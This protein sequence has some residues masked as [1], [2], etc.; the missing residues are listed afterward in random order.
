MYGEGVS[1][2]GEILDLGVKA[3]E[4]VEKSGAWFSYDEPASRPGPRKFKGLP[5]SQ[6]GDDGEDLKPR[7]GRTPD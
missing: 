7:S 3:G 2:M 5:E 6:S 4:I 1:K